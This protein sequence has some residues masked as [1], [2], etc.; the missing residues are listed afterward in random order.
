MVTWPLV[1]NLYLPAENWISS[2]EHGE[3]A[4]LLFLSNFMEGILIP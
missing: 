2:R 4:S 3:V 1:V